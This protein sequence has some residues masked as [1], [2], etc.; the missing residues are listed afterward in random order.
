MEQCPDLK[1]VQTLP[2]FSP[3]LGMRVDKPELPYH[4]LRVQRAINMAVNKQEIIDE[5]YGGHAE[6]LY[7][8]FIIL[9]RVY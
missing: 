1:Y 4:D 9:R 8:D 5:Y 3:I 2:D 7:V 6:F